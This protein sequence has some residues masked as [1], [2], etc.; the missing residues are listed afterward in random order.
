[1]HAFPK[2][3]PKL[4]LAVP[5]S[6]NYGPSRLFFKSMAADAGNVIVLTGRA[7]SDSLAQNLFLR[8]DQGQ[9][10][11]AMRYGLG[12]VG[13]LVH[14]DGRQHVTIDSKVA[15]VGKELEQHLEAQRQVKEKEAATKAAAERSRRMLEADDLES[16]SDSDA[17]SADM[18]L[19]GGAEDDEAPNG[20]L[21]GGTGTGDAFA[22]NEDVRATSFDIYVKG[23]QTRAVGFF[24]SGANTGAQQRFRMFPFVERKSRKVD[25][26][27]ENLDVGA[28]L[29]KGK[30]IEL[31]VESDEVKEA[32]RRKKEQDEKQVSTVVILGP[33]PQ[34]PR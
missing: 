1:M 4:V 16:D 6:L 25:I 22:E 2:D 33:P 21:E 9:A 10:T 29:R 19:D 15:L 18:H 17:D 13:D 5:I 27:G 26:Y 14:L 11:P 7:E 34:R 8:W 30:E 12:K 28:W 23:Q 31:E 3:L 20:L 24:R 32:K